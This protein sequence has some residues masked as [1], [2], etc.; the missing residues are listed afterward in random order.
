MGIAAIRCVKAWGLSACLLLA[1][2][3]PSTRENPFDVTPVSETTVQV[4]IRNQRFEDITVWAIW[5]GGSRVRVGMVTGY[6]TRSFAVEP[7]GDAVHFE[8]DFLAGRRFVG[9]A[10]FV[11]R[12]DQLELTLPFS[13]RPHYLI[14][15]ILGPDAGSE[16]K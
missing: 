16:P 3:A 9:Q 5:E 11:S 1:G 2:C 4:T 14:T 10:I 6:M 8:V 15:R 12:G 7:V 13:S